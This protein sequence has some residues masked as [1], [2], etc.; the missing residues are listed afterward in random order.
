MPCISEHLLEQV[1]EAELLK[2]ERERMAS[3]IMSASM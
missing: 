2:D 1:R 3:A